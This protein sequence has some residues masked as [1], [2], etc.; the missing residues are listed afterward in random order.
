MHT[1]RTCKLLIVVCECSTVLRK[2]KYHKAVKT[3]DT[4][5]YLKQLPPPPPPPPTL[6][7][8]P[9]IQHTVLL[10]SILSMYA[11]IHTTLWYYYM[12]YIRTQIRIAGHTLIKE[13]VAMRQPPT[14]LI[15]LTISLSATSEA[16]RACSDLSSF[17]SDSK[18]KSIN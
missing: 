18:W 13:G 5:Q 15:A 11:G 10:Q 14:L 12:Y 17:C 4:V 3:L 2:Y 8:L 16:W 9:Y 6:H 7:W 1:E